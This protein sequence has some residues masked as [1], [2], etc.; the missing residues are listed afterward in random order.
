[1]KWWGQ[2]WDVVYSLSSIMLAFLLGV[3][4]G[5][6][7]QGLAIGSNLEYQGSPL[8]GFLNPYAIITGFTTLS[9][10]MTHGAIYL[11]LKTEGKLFDKLEGLLESGVRDQ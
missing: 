5:N 11:L 2:L 9:L 7:L 3:V 8:L 4:L 6:V 1:M 10:F